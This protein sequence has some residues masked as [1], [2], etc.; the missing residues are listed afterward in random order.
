MVLDLA[1]IKDAETLLDTVN[2]VALFYGG[3][4]LF[5]ISPER[6][7]EFKKLFA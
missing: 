1:L 3:V 4:E 5:G 6:V 2:K 7:E